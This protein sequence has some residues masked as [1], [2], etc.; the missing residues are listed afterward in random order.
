VA[1]DEA[2]VESFKLGN[3][4]ALVTRLLCWPWACCC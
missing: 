3:A 1:A 4:Q 2:V